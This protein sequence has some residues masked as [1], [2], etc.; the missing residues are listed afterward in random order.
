[1]IEWYGVTE[2]E[3][4]VGHWPFS[5]QFQILI[6]SVSYKMLQCWQTGKSLLAAKL[7]YDHSAVTIS[8]LHRLVD[9]KQ[10]ISLLWSY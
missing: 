5:E 9:K 8:N 1:M 6:S 2:P 7:C 3:I 4:A 10:V